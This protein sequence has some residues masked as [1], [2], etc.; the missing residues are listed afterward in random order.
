MQ[1]SRYQLISTAIPL[2]STVMPGGQYDRE[3]RL[4]SGGRVST[5]RI[6]SIKKIRF[7]FS[8][9]T[10]REAECLDHSASVTS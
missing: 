3:K 7:A 9:E 1:Y 10:Q 6:G 8:T 2:N 4:I 5:H